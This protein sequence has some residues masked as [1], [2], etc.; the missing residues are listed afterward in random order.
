[1]LHEG[2][3]AHPPERAGT[4]GFPVSWPGMASKGSTVSQLREDIDSGRTRDKVDWPDPAAAP[5]G[6]DDEA[7]GNP[8]RSAAI[9]AARRRE[10]AAPVECTV[11]RDRPGAAWIQVAIVAVLIVAVIG[12]IVMMRL[13]A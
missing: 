8:P 10:K 13:S 11:E 9:D 5:L 1:L 2:S 12:W 7:G 3:K 4:A 6:T